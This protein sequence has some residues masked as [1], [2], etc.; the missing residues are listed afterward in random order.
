[1]TSYWSHTSTETSSRRQIRRCALLSRQTQRQ[2][3]VARAPEHLLRGVSYVK[4]AV[5][6]ALVLVNLRNRCRHADH[7]P[8]V[9]QQ[10][11]GLAGTQLQP[12]SVGTN[13]LGSGTTIGATKCAP[14]VLLSEEEWRSKNSEGAK[15]V[16][17]QN[18]LRCLWEVELP[19]Y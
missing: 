7:A 16:E 1:M 18:L 4:E 9:H 19:E 8:L 5:V 10:E 14:R 13:K 3:N 12:A 17:E 2:L 11:E 6:I 15:R